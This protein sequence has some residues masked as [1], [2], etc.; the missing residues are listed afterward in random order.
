MAPRTGNTPPQ[1]EALFTEIERVLDYDAVTS[2]V[3]HLSRHLFLEGLAKIPRAGAVRE[4]GRIQ[5]EFGDISDEE[6]LSPNSPASLAINRTQRAEENEREAEE[7]LLLAELDIARAVHISVFT[8]ENAGYGNRKYRV[9]AEDPGDQ[10]KLNKATT[11]FKRFFMGDGNEDS[12]ETAAHRRDEVF[13]GHKLEIPGL[14]DIMLQKP[15]RETVPVSIPTASVGEG[16]TKDGEIDR[17]QWLWWARRAFKA[18]YN[19]RIRKEN[20][21]DVRHVPSEN[22]IM[23]GTNELRNQGLIGKQ[24]S[25]IQLESLAKAWFIRSL[26]TPPDSEGNI[27]VKGDGVKN[28]DELWDK[29]MD[30][31]NAERDD[32]ISASLID[33][34]KHLKAA[35][36]S[37]D[38]DV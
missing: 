16:L 4:F 3:R 14:L 5:G 23:M 9:V 1:T 12:S 36:E 27:E 11:L 18:T 37:F 8:E 38:F 2:A 28:I 21:S 30:D 34:V 29:F 10:R 24:L 32:E 20:K 22:E 17:L 19:M 15:S 13:H 7:H 33:R 35:Q 31:V 25:I 26:E 6:I